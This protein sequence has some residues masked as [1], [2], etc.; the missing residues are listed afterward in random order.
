VSLQQNAA[1]DATSA[2]DVRDD[3]SQQGSIREARKQEAAAQLQANYHKFKAALCNFTA[4]SPYVAV[5]AACI[6]CMHVVA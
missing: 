3:G 1:E 5:S 4:V 2:D 6:D